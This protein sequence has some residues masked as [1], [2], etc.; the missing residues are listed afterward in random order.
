MWAKE[1]QVHKIQ[2]PWE[3]L[4]MILEELGGVGNNDAALCSHSCSLKTDLE[5]L[6]IHARNSCVEM[7]PTHTRRSYSWWG[8]G[9][10]LEVRLG[11]IQG[12]KVWSWT[13]ST[14]TTWELVR[15][16]ASQA[17]P[18]SYSIRISGVGPSNLCFANPSRWLWYSLKSENHGCWRIGAV[19]GVL[20]SN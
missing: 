20:L 4:P 17:P 2:V 7:C 6:M 9:S 11:L 18:K 8:G 19:M 3:K 5:W 13:R 14:S 15:L 1:R 12:L 10:E 16:A